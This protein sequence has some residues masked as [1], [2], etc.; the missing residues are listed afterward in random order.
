MTTD[1]P[2]PFPFP[3]G[4]RDVAEA[5]PAA[6]RA[7][8]QRPKAPPP[9]NATLPPRTPAH[10]PPSREKPP[11]KKETPRTQGP[12]RDPSRIRFDAFPFAAVAAQEPIGYRPSK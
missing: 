3:V 2:N 12:R 1:D 7:R 9:G 10:R 8:R 11:K 4:P 6:R 5:L